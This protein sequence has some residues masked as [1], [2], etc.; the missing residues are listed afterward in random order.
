MREEIQSLHLTAASENN[1]SNI[2][3]SSGAFQELKEGIPF[4][5][6]AGK[7]FPQ[8]TTHII[9]NAEVYEYVY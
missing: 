8:T 9:K 3:L 6:S 5:S 2:C 4:Q 1:L 7:S